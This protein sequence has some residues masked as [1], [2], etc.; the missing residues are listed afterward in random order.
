MLAPSVEMARMVWKRPVK[1]VMTEE[2]EWTDMGSMWSREWPCS[3]MM[4]V[5][6]LPFGNRRW[7]F[8][9]L[10]VCCRGVIM[11]DRPTCARYSKDGFSALS[12]LDVNGWRRC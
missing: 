5:V 3:E 4:P 2:P 9:S 12:V 1:K 10:V 11:L 7:A 6:V 8:A